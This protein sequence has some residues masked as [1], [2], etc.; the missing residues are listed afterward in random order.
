[1]KSATYALTTAA[2]LCLLGTGTA[3]AAP[4]S[5]QRD[6]GPCYAHEIGKDS[7]DGTLHCSGEN[8]VWESKTVQRA[9]HVQ[10][11]APCSRLG[12]RAIVLRTDGGATCRETPHG[13]QWQW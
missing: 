5:V 6:G 2:L 11:G 4:A 7:A 13:L 1:M 9:P 3:T 8:A 12:A 10:L